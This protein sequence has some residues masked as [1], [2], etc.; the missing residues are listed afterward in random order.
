M[1][2]ALLYLGVTALSIFALSS[3]VG[4]GISKEA[5]PAVVTKGL[6]LVW[7]SEPVIT[8]LYKGYE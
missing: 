6:V 8:I 3:A 2:K 4:E 5:E 1:K 7:N